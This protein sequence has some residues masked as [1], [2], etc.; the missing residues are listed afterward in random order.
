MMLASIAKPSPPTS[1][2]PMHRSTTVSKSWRNASL[3]RNRP[4]R[5]FEN[6]EWSGIAASSPGRQ[7]VQA[8]PAGFAMTWKRRV[9]M[10]PSLRDGVFVQ[11][12]C[13]V[14]WPRGSLVQLR[15]A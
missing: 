7:V 6:V 13:Q 1:P 3:S 15:V 11:P 9:A 10:V 5:F 14:G 12:K 4:C 8:E 2:S